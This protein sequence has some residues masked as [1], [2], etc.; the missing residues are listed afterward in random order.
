MLARNLDRL[1]RAAPIRNNDFVLRRILGDPLKCGSQIPGLIQRGDNDRNHALMVSCC[2]DFSEQN[3]PGWVHKMKE[4][5]AA[6]VRAA[7]CE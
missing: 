7:Q 6:L 5:D 3:G 2:Q 1:I 4:L